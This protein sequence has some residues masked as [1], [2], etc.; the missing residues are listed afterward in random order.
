MPTVIY[1]SFDF[2]NIE[3]S[4][5]HFGYRRSPTCS[6][7]SKKVIHSAM[8]SGVRLCDLEPE[9]ERSELAE[10]ALIVYA[11]IRVKK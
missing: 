5:I 3:I 1:I 11:T 2:W 6:D 7:P 8:F 9:Q 10:H 4:V